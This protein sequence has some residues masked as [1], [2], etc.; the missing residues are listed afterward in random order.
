MQTTLL[1]ADLM[2]ESGVG[3]GTSGAR[4]L[5][6]AMTDRVCYVYTLGF[7]QYLSDSQQ[8]S[9]QRKVVVAG[10]YRESTDKIMQA[11]MQAVVDAGFVVEN[12]G[13][14]PSPAVALRGI[15]QATPAIM[16]TGSHIPDDRN[17]IKFNKPV[18]EILKPDELGI[19]Q[20]VVTFNSDMFGAQGSF[21]EALNVINVQSQARDFYLKR[22]TDFFPK[23]VLSGLSVGLYQHSGVAREILF[24]LLSGLGAKVM[25][26][27]YSDQFMPVDTEAIR[28]E[29]V[30]LARQWAKEYSLDAIVSTDGDGDRPLVAN[31]QGEWFRG[32]IVG[33]LCARFLG[34]QSI[35][36]PIS[37]NSV[38]ELSE[39]FQRVVRT[40]IGSPFVIEMMQ[41]L[42][43]KGE[44]G[45]VGY[46]ANGG[47]LQADVCEKE[48]RY[49][50]A[51]PTRDAVIVILSLLVS[52][53]QQS[54]CLSELTQDL[55]ARFTASDRLKDFPKE[56]SQS[57][58]Q[59]LCS[60]DFEHNKKVID[61]LFND[62]VVQMNT[63]DGL[64]MTFAAGHIIHLR[65]SGNAPELRC[66]TEAETVA[67]AEQLN[68]QTLTI[69]EHWRAQ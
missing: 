55:P 62:D 31:E 58:I 10:D 50:S 15:S 61:M 24:E 69:L 16:V 46:E 37:S 53:K 57:R 22:F 66:Y 18:G 45:V 8:L 65:P 64:R 33:I 2:Q 39:S 56:M 36:T 4:G 17:G 52:A 9:E 30:K 41:K 51:L 19:K 7:L 34:S 59:S 26:L 6:S 27:G 28:P 60:S 48:G 11:V 68:Q 25:P 13:C 21:V 32:D 44:K 29:D 54:K 42:L 23:Q 40:Q 63:L 12:A 14:I 47:F 3:F 49:L 5:V 20:Q 67:A 38:V 43:D 1:I 35:V